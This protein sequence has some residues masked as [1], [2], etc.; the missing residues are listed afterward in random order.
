[1]TLRVIEDLP[2]GWAGVLYD[3]GTGLGLIDRTRGAGNN[4]ARNRVRPSS[5]LNT[6]RQGQG[7]RV[8]ITDRMAADGG[9]SGCWRGGRGQ[10]GAWS[11]L[12]GN[13]PGLAGW[14]G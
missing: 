1:V 6:A 3:I 14:A 4:G 7:V 13:A 10:R 9:N 2:T 8:T 5:L 11:R 12:S